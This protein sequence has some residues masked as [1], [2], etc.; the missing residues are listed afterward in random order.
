VGGLRSYMHTQCLRS[1]RR[2]G[3]KWCMITQAMIKLILYKSFY[4]LDVSL[5]LLICEWRNYN[6]KFLFK[7]AV[8]RTV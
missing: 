4:H 1:V 3:L 2:E 7:K 6:Y 5:D 8:K